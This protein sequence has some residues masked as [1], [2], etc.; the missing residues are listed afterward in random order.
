MKHWCSGSEY[1][2]TIYQLVYSADKMWRRLAWAGTSMA[3]R[4]FERSMRSKV[5][6][7]DNAIANTT[8]GPYQ[9]ELIHGRTLAKKTRKSAGQASLAWVG[10]SKATYLPVPISD[11]LSET[12]TASQ[13]WSLASQIMTV[14][15]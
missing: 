13:D 15:V 12:D 9:N 10:R 11:I 8:N 7:Y 4:A 2:W 1:V 5:F 6:S 14:M 3:G